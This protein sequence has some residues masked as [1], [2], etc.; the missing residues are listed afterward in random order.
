MLDD[1][2][3]SVKIR[4]NFLNLMSSFKSN[5][6]I[7]SSMALPIFCNNK[8]FNDD[9]IDLIMME[10]YVKYRNEKNDFI[11]LIVK[12]YDDKSFLRNMFYNNYSFA[13]EL[14]YNAFS[15]DF[16]AI[17]RRESFDSLSNEQRKIATSLSKTCNLINYNYISFY[18]RLTLLK[19][20]LMYNDPENDLLNVDY[21]VD[22]IE[23]LKRYILSDFFTYTRYFDG[24]FRNNICYNIICNYGS[25]YQK[26]WS[27][28]EKRDMLKY[29][30]HRAVQ[31]FLEV[32]DFTEVYRSLSKKDEDFY[33]ILNQVNPFIIVD[34]IESFSKK[35]RK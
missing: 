3:K 12:K 9:I 20:D 26:A 30:F 33:N 10:Y 4:E 35:Y 34:E 27:Q 8:F 32:S 22:N 1:L 31:C 18:A 15:V 16:Y 11:D 14:V 17:D 6:F 25:D 29:C 28:I 5:Q 21:M 24:D 2:V 19:Y 7:N 23:V 13:F